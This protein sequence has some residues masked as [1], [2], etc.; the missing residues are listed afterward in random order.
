MVKKNACVFISGSGTNLRSL[1]KSSREY[2]FPIN[3]SFIISNTKKAKGIKFAKLYKIPF[4]ILNLNNVINLES[5]LIELQKKNIS[6]IC[7][8]GYMKIL[9]KKFIR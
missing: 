4:V 7:L 8:A 1:I 3:I 2:N 9:N 6:I 5:I